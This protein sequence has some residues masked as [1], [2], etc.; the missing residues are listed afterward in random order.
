VRDGILFPI[1]VLSVTEVAEYRNA[2]ESVAAMCGEGYRR[3]FDNL[4]LF[5][6]WAYRLATNETVLDAVEGILG[7]DLVVDA[8]LVF[9]KPPSDSGYTAWHQDSVY[10]N[11]HL[12][13]AVSAWIALTSSEP[14]NGCMRVVPGSHRDGVL[15]HDTIVDDP[16]LMN[17]RG[18]RVRNDVDEAQVVDVILRPGEMS[19]HHANIV[20]GSNANG[21]DGPR[22]GF[23]VRF[24]TS[25][26]TNRDRLQMQVRG[27]ADCSHLR[28]APAPLEEDLAIAVTAWQAREPNSVASAVRG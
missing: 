9:Y 16:D 6:P 14:A 11:W 23:I 2:L 26:T 27:D 25:Q 10:S 22:I 18:E 4:H 21:S 13:P 17:R 7:P 5:F 24:V 8:T 19:L 12:T 20:H 1:P 3:R 15:E 28:M